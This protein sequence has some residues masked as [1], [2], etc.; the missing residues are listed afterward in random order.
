[1]LAL[2]G[3]SAAPTEPAPMATPL[4]V[5]TATPPA[6]RT[7]TMTATTAP[8]PTSTETLKPTPT[9]E[10][11]TARLFA[12]GFLPNWGF[13]FTIEAEEPIQMNYYGI[14]ARDKRYNCEVISQNPNRIYCYGPLA[15]VDRWVDYGVYEEETDR[16]VHA[17]RFFIPIELD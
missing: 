17:G 1:M 12:T 13:F 15:A 2:A 8:V 7:P 9:S 16:L 14:V 11:D 10:M 4:Q 5:N 6:T 3:C